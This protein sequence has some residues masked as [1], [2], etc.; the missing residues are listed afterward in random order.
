MTKRIQ[1]RPGRKP[2]IRG[3]VGGD[4]PGAG[5]AL[6]F[7]RPSS[8]IAAGSRSARTTKTERGICSRRDGLAF[9][10]SPAEDRLRAD[11][12]HCGLQARQSL[13]LVGANLLDHT[14]CLDPL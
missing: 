7:L 10:R 4:P 5:G 11:V 2:G 3:G 13:E 6:A 9:L 12:A 1:M 14:L 8:V